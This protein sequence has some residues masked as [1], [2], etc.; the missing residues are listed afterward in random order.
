MKTV[1]QMTLFSFLAYHDFIELV[2]KTLQDNVKDKLLSAK[3]DL[4]F[5][6]IC[7]GP[8][9]DKLLRFSPFGPS[10]ALMYVVKNE[11]NNNIPEYTIVIRGTNPKSPYSWF[12]E[13]FNVK[14]LKKW[15]SVSWETKASDNAQVSEA[16][17]QAMNIHTNLKDNNTTVMDWLNS[18]LD[19][20]PK[21]NIKLNITGHSLGGLLSTTLGLWIYDNLAKK[22]LKDFVDINIYSFAAPTAGNKEFV[23]YTRSKLGEKFTCFV[24]NLD[25]ATHAWVETDMTGLL[26]KIY[27]PIKLSKEEAKILSDFCDK[28]RNHEY[29]KI[30][31]ESLIASEILSTL[32]IYILQAVYQHLVPYLQAIKDDAPKKFYSEVCELLRTLYNNMKPDDLSGNPLTIKQEELDQFFFMIDEQLTL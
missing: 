4:G 24:N 6:E 18:I 23:E 32:D 10:I 28:I 19:K 26:P 1:T 3:K 31:N 16:T 21:Q 22:N 5:S 8:V 12:R 2:P 30:G 25:I 29:Q 7:W 15:N 20:S 11:N 17:S 13:D 27:E 14:E 9:A